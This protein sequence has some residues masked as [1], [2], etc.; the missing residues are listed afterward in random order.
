MS[1]TSSSSTD[2]SDEPEVTQD[3]PDGDPKAKATKDTD[4]VPKSEAEKAYKRR[5]DAVNARKAA[6]KR[7]EELEFQV[8]SFDTKLA[9]LSALQRKAEDDEAHKRGDLDALRKSASDAQAEL[10]TRI[11]ELTATAEKAKAD[12]R[13]EIDGFKNTYLLKEGVMRVLSETTTD[14]ELAWL[15]LGHHFELGEEEDGSFKPRVKNDTRD[16]KT[17]VERKFE[18]SNREVLLKSR[19][20]SGT[21]SETLP[22]KNGSKTQYTVEQLDAMSGEDRRKYYRENP[23]AA[24]AAL[25]I[26]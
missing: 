20:K 9:E 6:E 1:D 5:D 12:A 25:G 11:A 22:E 3:A 17:F 19:R 26:K 7:A 13:A 24:K 18:E 8:K 4:F 21:G 23:D 14:P 16:I 10:N 2:G 15:A